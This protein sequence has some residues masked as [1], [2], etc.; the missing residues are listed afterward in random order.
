MLYAVSS[1][2]FFTLATQHDVVMLFED[3]LLLRP[4]IH[5]N[6]ETE[7][8]ASELEGTLAE[9]DCERVCKINSEQAAC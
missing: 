4:L 1:C 6:M 7:F 8:R 2:D 3:K 9:N 5:A